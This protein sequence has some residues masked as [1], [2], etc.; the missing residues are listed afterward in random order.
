MRVFWKVLAVFVI[1]AGIGRPCWAGRPDHDYLVGAYYYPWYLNDFH[2]GNYLREHLV[3]PQ[4][5]EL[6]EYNDREA[7][8]INQHL[9]WSRDAGVDFWVAS[10]WG[11]GGRE[12][13]TLKDYIFTSSQL[14]SLKIALFYETVGRTSNFSDFSRIA[15]DITYIATTYFSHPNYLKVDGRPV[16]FVYLTRVLT[17]Y[18]TLADT[19]TT[20]R[21]AASAQGYDIYLVGDEVFGSP[22]TSTASIA[23][24]DAITNYDVYGSTGASGHAG[25]AAV[26]NYYSAQSGWRDLAH[27]A[28]AAFIPAV[29]PGFNDK[30]VRTGHPL[31]SR[32]LTAGGEFGSLFEAMLKGAKPLADADIDYMLMVT[33]W[34]EWHEDTQIEPVAAADPTNVDNSGSYDYTNGYYYEGYGSRYLDILEQETVP[35]PS[36]PSMFDEEWNA[37]LTDRALGNDLDGDGVQDNWALHVVGTILEADRYPQHAAFLEAYRAHLE[38]LDGEGSAVVPY[39]RALAALMLISQ[40]LQ[41]AIVSEFSLSGTYQTIG[42][43]PVL[44]G[45]DPDGDAF[46]NL[47]EYQGIIAWGGTIDHYPQAVL[48]SAWDGQQPLPAAGLAA[49]VVL[50]ACCAVLAGMRLRSK[51]RA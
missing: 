28:G 51:P 13:V 8:T 27:T 33:S 39:R 26:D 7:A 34:N 43:W 38:E 16:L 31:L 25:Q 37:L 4:L 30:G 15:P 40:D 12:D 32:K 2:G 29:S 49:L 20:M 1:L 19:V 5:P 47:A 14:G 21:A 23:R 48:N 11:A 22:P 42:G 6:G 45:S 50:A 44:A 41:N 46:T 35:F 9:S 36:G 10:W 17:A 24:L 18:G 3:P